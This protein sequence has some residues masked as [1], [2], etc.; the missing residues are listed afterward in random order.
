MQ[1]SNANIEDK[2]EQY[3]SNRKTRMS[4]GKLQILQE[5]SATL[6]FNDNDRSHILEPI[7][8]LQADN[9]G[10]LRLPRSTVIVAEGVYN[11]CWHPKEEVGFWEK[12]IYDPKTLKTSAI[13]VLNLN[14]ANGIGALGFIQNRLLA[15]RT[16]ELSIGFWCTEEM[17]EV[18]ID[19]VKT[20]IWTVRNWEYD[21]VALVYRGACSPEDGAGIGLKKNNLIKMEEKVMTENKEKEAGEEKKELIAETIVIDK[22]QKG[23]FV[24]REEFQKGVQEE[25]AKTIEE[26]K[27]KEKLELF[28]NAI[29]KE[30]WDEAKKLNPYNEEATKTNKDKY[31]D[32]LD[33]RIVELEKRG[34]GRTTP[35]RDMMPSGTPSNVAEK[36]DKD[37]KAYK[38]RSA[39]TTKLLLDLVAKHPDQRLEIVKKADDYDD[40]PEWILERF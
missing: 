13:P 15:G 17:E 8:K 5:C 24:S 40:V 21:H 22:T 36:Q 2:Y 39:R 3:R 20:K 33:E 35:T 25:L 38:I 16:P 26:N 32:A 31:L 1:P 6:V 10:S 27:R 23:D 18:V 37:S 12:P 11:G 30:D 34:S 7:E 19:G 4:G 14:T 29:K 28:Q 9:D